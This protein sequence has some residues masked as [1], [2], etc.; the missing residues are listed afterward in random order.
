MHTLSG[1]P[2][3][4]KVAAEHYAAQLRDLRSIVIESSDGVSA[5]IIPE[6]QIR[7]LSIKED[8]K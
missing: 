8:A 2:H 4:V 6:G 1:I 5:I 3:S 7:F